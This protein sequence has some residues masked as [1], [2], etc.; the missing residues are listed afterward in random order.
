MTFDVDVI[1]VG[2]GPPGRRGRRLRRLRGNRHRGA[3]FRDGRADPPRRLYRLGRSR[4]RD[5]RI[6]YP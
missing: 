5:Q 2:A 1:I 6:A 3:P 4:Q